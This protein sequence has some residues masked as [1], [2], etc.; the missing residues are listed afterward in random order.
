MF[1]CTRRSRLDDLTL[2]MI[3]PVEVWLEIWQIFFARN[4]LDQETSSES[5]SSKLQG[6][7]SFQKFPLILFWAPQFRLSGLSFGV[8]LFLLVHPAVRITDKISSVPHSRKTCPTRLKS[9]AKRTWNTQPNSALPK[10]PPPLIIRV[11]NVSSTFSYR[12][13][14]VT[15]TNHHGTEPDPHYRT[16]P[17]SKRP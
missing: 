12:K 15:S 2:V 1:F 14:A 8:T 10:I 6:F 11:H 5:Y 7:P 3:T 13:H 16:V 17:T 4:S 9:S